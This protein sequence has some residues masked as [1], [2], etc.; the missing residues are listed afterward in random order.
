MTI[1]VMRKVKHIFQPTGNSCGPTC[2]KMV[3]ETLNGWKD[4]SE[5]F[6]DINKIS[7]MCGTDWVVGT[8][9]DRM[10]NGMK[11][12]KMKYVE[13]IASPRPYELLKKVIDDGNIAI[14]RTITDG[15]PHW[16]VV[17]G[18]YLGW[19]TLSDDKFIILDPWKGERLSNEKDLDLIW[20]PRD[21]QF[22][23]IIMNEH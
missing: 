4:S 23:E 7:K 18:Y 3:H 19:P 15:I 6:P 10:E 2:L 16:V 14:I 12:L 5:P 17:G 9:P 11:A 20:K 22:F 8:P 21:Y 1:K 13:Y